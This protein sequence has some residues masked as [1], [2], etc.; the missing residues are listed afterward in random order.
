MSDTNETL[1][2]NAINIAKHHKKHCNGANCLVSLI[3]LRLLLA[4]AGIELT[5]EEIEVFI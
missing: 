5:N 4:R 3:S 2:L 1:K